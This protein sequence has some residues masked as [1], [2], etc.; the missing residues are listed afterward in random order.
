MRIGGILSAQSTRAGHIGILAGPHRQAED[1]Q[2]VPRIRQDKEKSGDNRTAIE[3]FLT[4][5]GEWGAALRRA[6]Q[7]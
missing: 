3:L 4:G 5:I 1:R 2:P 7:G 6:F